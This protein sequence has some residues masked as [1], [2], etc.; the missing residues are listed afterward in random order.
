MKTKT[1]KAFNEMAVAIGKYIKAMGGEAMVVG[2]IEI[3][4]GLRKFNY[5]LRIG[6]TGKQPTKGNL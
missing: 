5:T 2:G 1:D 4:Q 3:E 6:I